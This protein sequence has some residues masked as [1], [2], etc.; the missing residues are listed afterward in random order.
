VRDLGENIPPLFNN[1]M[2]LSPTMRTFG[3]TTNSHFGDVEET[4]IMV[5][6]QDIYDQKKDR[7]VLPYLEYLKS[8]NK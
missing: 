7:Y 1:Y 3:T 5:T 8:K 6:I 2:N 4:G